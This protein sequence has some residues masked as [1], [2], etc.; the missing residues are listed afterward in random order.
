MRKRCPNC[1]GTGN[2]RCEVH[3]QHVCS[4]C[5][6]KGCIEESKPSI[7]VPEFYPGKYI[8]KPWTPARWEKQKVSSE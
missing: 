1:E 4:R 8:P 3:G 5:N 6:G 2:E 7:V